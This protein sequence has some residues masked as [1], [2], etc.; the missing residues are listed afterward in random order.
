MKI[1]LI[2]H[3]LNL[4]KSI[5]SV[6]TDTMFPKSRVVDY[7]DKSNFIHQIEQLV[8]E[9]PTNIMEASRWR[10]IHRYDDTVTKRVSDDGAIRYSDVFR[11]WTVKVVEVDITRPWTIK[12]ITTYDDDDNVSDM[13]ET[14]KYLDYTQ[15]V[16]EMNYCEEA[17]A[18][19]YHNF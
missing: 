2:L 11:Y 5:E 10:C 7:D 17:K 18:D 12:T 8:K 13:Y 9:E 6:F 14:I 3:R 15:I 1:A 16:P 19:D 4:P